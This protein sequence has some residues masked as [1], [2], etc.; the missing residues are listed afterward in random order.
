MPG[1]PLIHNKPPFTSREDCAVTQDKGTSPAEETQEL[2]HE[3]GTKTADGLLEHDSPAAGQ[4]NAGAQLETP[5]DRHARLRKLVQHHCKKLQ[6]KK[7]LV[8]DSAAAHTLM[9]LEALYQFNDRRLEFEQQRASLIASLKTVA[10]RLQPR[11][12]IRISRIKPSLKASTAI[13]THCSRG[14]SYAQ[15]IRSTAAYLL[16]TGLLPESKQG[17]GAY[18]ESLLNR[19][20]ISSALQVWVKGVLSFEEGG[21][22]GRVSLFTTS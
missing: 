2:D 14:P 22:I 11:L 9:D 3:C 13:A 21:F 4:R 6:S 1:S 19:Q 15:T 8:S 16:Q 5:E 7:S 10:R 18:H 20:E 12:K 17:K